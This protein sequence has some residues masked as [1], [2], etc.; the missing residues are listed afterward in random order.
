MI[1]AVILKNRKKK[2]AVQQKKK[3]NL[4]VAQQKK[5]KS[6]NP[7]AAANALREFS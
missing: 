3:T 7:L 6:K 1:N 5:A 4:N 2:N